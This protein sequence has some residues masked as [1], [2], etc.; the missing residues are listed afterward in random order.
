MIQETAQMECDQKNLTYNDHINNKMIVQQS[1]I[2]QLAHNSLI[3][4]PNGQKKN[5]TLNE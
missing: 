2:Q 5:N 4:P 3:L 1:T